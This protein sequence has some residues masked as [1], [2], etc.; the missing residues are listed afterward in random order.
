[1]VSFYWKLIS[2]LLVYSVMTSHNHQLRTKPF[3]RP[4]DQVVR[5]WS[6]SMGRQNTPQIG[7]LSQQVVGR[8]TNVEYL[9]SL[10]LKRRGQLLFQV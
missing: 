5:T 7:H 4:S 2:D 10:Y 1:M 9:Q 6:R 3:W 8:Y